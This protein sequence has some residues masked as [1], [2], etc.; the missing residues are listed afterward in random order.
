MR[1]SL[2]LIVWFAL[3]INSVQ[4][5]TQDE[6]EIYRD[7]MNAAL[8]GFKANFAK[9]IAD[10]EGEYK[11]YAAMMKQEF[12]D[13]KDEMERMWGDFK[14]R[15]KTEWVE[16]MNGG[17]TRVQTN[18]ETGQVTVEVIVEEPEN[19]DEEIED[20][21][22]KVV[23]TIQS[24]GTQMG[25][26]S[27]DTPEEAPALEE[28][29]LK[30]QVDKEPEETNEDFAERVTENNVQQTTVTGLDGVKRTVLTVNFALAPNHIQTRAEKVSSHVYDF[31]E[32]YELDPPLVFAI[33]HTESYFNPMAASAANAY[34]LMQLVPTSGGRDAYR[35]VFK[36]D[37][38]P[39]KKFLFEPNN[40]V[41]LGCAYVNIL[42]NNYLKDV[43][44]SQTKMYMAISAYNTG[45]GNVYKAYD[46]SRSKSKA[47]RKLETM[48]D[49]E[50]YDYLIE[51][52]P[53]EETRG[54]LEK[55]VSRSKLY[56]GWSNK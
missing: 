47:M 13:Y 35:K 23:Q 26:E 9:E 52:L 11:A 18:F 55:V 30:D 28:P 20:L 1:Y 27:D 48:S 34:G 16:Y 22:E 2:L 19:V 44:S 43:K 50:N 56:E 4:A 41:K 53:Y 15:S 24:Q 49:Q 8:E 31:S 32:E 12:E 7:S 29:V 33:I 38:I 54:Y 21:P 45:V 51:N 17:T 42:L 3:G 39:T 6:Y 10:T 46:P 5:Q 40:N 37:G 36:K 25:F 14:E